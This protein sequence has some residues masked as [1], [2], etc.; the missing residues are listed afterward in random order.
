MLTSIDSSWHESL[1]RALGALSPEYRDF[2]ESST[3]FIPSRDR[4]LSAFST[5]PKDRVKYILF[6]QDPYP[7]EQSA[8]G[9][10][11]IDGGVD[12]LFCD[13]G[14]SKL[15][16]RATSLC[17]FMKMALVASGRLDSTDTTQPAIASID[18]NDIISNM[19]ELRVNFEHSGVL[20]LNTALVFTSKKDSKK[21]IKAWK[22][23]VE[24]L[25]Q[26][27][28]D[29]QPSLILFGA[30]AKELMKISGIEQFPIISMEHP[31]NHTFICNLDAHD[32]FGPMNLLEKQRS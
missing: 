32:L 13:N 20:L 10:A 8:I 28:L 27:M 5:L 9:Y 17:N 26:E 25:L 18:K 7:R 16:N 14:L 29:Q 19:T 23:F 11:F 15:V 3:D 30:H 6:G 31:Y 2:L 24:V 1:T 12:E 22:G 21:H 4:L